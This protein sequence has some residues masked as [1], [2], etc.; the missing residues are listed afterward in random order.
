M[1]TAAQIREWAQGEGIPVS[2]SG[3]VS[4][5][6]RRRFEKV[7]GEGGGA[8]DPPP[9]G[10][11]DGG[12]DDD[13]G[14]GDGDTMTEADLPPGAST[15]AAAA[16]PPGADDGDAAR[17]AAQAAARGDV[18]RPRGGRRPGLRD[19]LRGAQGGAGK[20]AGKAAGKP[21]AGK[22]R[23]TPPRTDT[24]QLLG[25]GWGLL[26]R[27]VSP[28][29]VPTSRC[30]AAQRPVAGKMLDQIVKGTPADRVLQPLAR[31]EEK[32]DAVFALLGMPAAVFALHANPGAAPVVMPILRECVATYIRLAGPILDDIQRENDE[33]EEMYG[34]RVDQ[35]LAMFF[36]GVAGFD[37]SAGPPPGHPD[38]ASWEAA[39]QARRQAAA[40]G[41]AA[42]AAQAPPG[43]GWT[44]TAA[45]EPAGAPA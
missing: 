17:T 44:W 33:F 28:V 16:D 1:A 27:A 20:A 45:A 29:S 35:L 31:Y 8:A 23:R 39:E 41:Q 11:G 3:R 9:D 6:L 2:D 10:D 21:G 18:Q 15:A 7:H 37:P 14:D 5:S 19:R 4:G 24:T 25:R 42:A 43:A 40:E 12:Q 32:A 38:R 26:A 36:A 30:L 13:G 34:A 22:G